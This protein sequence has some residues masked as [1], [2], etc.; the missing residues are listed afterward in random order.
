[1]S[2]KQ[3]KAQAATQRVM[4]AAEAEAH[5][6]LPK[7]QEQDASTV[8]ES[9]IKATEV[10]TQPTPQAPTA[11]PANPQVQL[12]NGL[13]KEQFLTSHGNNK[14]KAIRALHAA[15]MAVGPISKFLGIKYQ[16]ARNVLIQP[17][18]AKVPN[19]PAPNE[20]NAPVVEQ[21]AKEGV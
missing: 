16:H 14:S 20:A 18:G 21:R 11:T 9:G 17:L 13:T 5:T 2:N 1:M 12:V 6:V 8:A 10:V 3:T 15:G 7:T 4:T 19:P